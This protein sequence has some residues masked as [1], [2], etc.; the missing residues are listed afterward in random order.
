[1]TSKAGGKA[2]AAGV[3]ATSFLDLKA[4]LAKKEDEFARSKASGTSRAI[5]GGVKRPEKVRLH[6]LFLSYEDID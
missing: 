4:E 5:I 6:A 2:R 1:M 3:S